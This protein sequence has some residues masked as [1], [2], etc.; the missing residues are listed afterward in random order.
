[1]RGQAGSGELITRPPKVDP[2]FVTA[3]GRGI[4]ILRCFT[5]ERPELG[6]TDIAA[7]I[8]L[9]QST[10]WRL[11]HTLSQLGCL[12]PGR[13]PEKLRVGLGALTLGQASLTHSG[14]AEVAYPAMK[15]IADRFGGSLSLAGRDGPNMVIVQRAEANTILRLQLHVGSALDIGRSALGWAY[16]AGA[17]TEEREDVIRTVAL[18]SPAG[19]PELRARLDAAAAEYRAQG[20]IMNIRAYHP[21]VNAIGVPVVG[22]NGRRVMALNCGGASS[23]MTRNTLCGPIAS[24]LMGLARRLAALV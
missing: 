23:V 9:P 16:Y 8:G 3:L 14:V 12:V 2:Q 21:E 10:V 22:G 6:T 24:E 13:N 17:L 5:P 4:E 19:E 1:V 11:C 20:F 7:L 15:E 18:N